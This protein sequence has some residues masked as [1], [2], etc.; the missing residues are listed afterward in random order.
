MNWHDYFTYTNGELFWKV[1]PNRRI[2]IGS[3]AGIETPK[4]YVSI[5]L[6]GKK[7]LAHRII[8][9]M[10]NGRIPPNMEVDHI[11]GIRNDNRISELRLV[12]SRGNRCNTAKRSDNSSGT[13]GVTFCKKLQKWKAYVKQEGKLIH[14]GY[15]T[16]KCDAIHARKAAEPIY[17][18]SQRHGL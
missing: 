17:G 16:D 5:T 13:T 6:M 18:F 1:S 2:K 8:W 11:W 12:T 15:F 4:G 7:Y 14:L 3:K 9:E 10:H